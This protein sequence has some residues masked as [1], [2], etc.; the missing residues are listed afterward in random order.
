MY[1]SEVTYFFIMKVD[2]GNESKLVSHVLLA[3][4]VSGVQQQI[5]E[6]VNYFLNTKKYFELVKMNTVGNGNTL[7]LKKISTFRRCIFG[8]SCSITEA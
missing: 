5:L 3:D 6:R 8:T 2:A 4:L 7:T 1:V